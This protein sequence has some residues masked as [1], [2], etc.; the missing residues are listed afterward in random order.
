MKFLARVKPEGKPRRAGLF[1]APLPA[2]TDDPVL[3]MGQYSDQ[4]PCLIVD[5]LQYLNETG[6]QQ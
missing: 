1:G 4:V 2:G 5:I 3:L 6:S